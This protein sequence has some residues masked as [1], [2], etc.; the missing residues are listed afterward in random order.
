MQICPINQDNTNFK[1]LHVSKQSL[2]AMGTSRR[3]LLKNPMIKEAADKF[4][5]LVKPSK[6]M[7]EISN[8]RN[9]DIKYSY[10]PS[11]I[12]AASFLGL[13]T[14]IGAATI[15]T[16]AGTIGGG[17]LGF[18]IGPMFALTIKNG[19][20]VTKEGVLSDKKVSQILVQAGENFENGKLTGITSSIYELSRPKD[21]MPNIASELSRKMYETKMKTIDP[22]NL[23]TAEKYLEMLENYTPMAEHFNKKIN[24]KGDTLLTQFFDVVPDD[25][26]TLYNKIIDILK[27]I[28]GLDYNQK[29]SGNI[30]CLE[31][32]MNA[33]NEEVL[34]LVQDFEFNYTPELEY[35]FANIKNKNFKNKVQK[36]IIN[37]NDILDAVKI[38]SDD[39]LKK[40]EN[41]LDS[42]LCN[43]KKLA[44]DIE[45]TLKDM[46]DPVYENWFK[47]IYGKYMNISASNLID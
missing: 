1:A 21:N 25:G 36:L 22:D 23:F 20:F 34:P 41:Q 47:S 33:E 12:G 45:K 42:P 15:G 28:K 19:E 31:K 38:K 3:A 11:L 8:E 14:Y 44:K 10:I 32:I 24:D 6:N 9:L 39:A 26:K 43:R 5:V 40:L 30:S 16:V 46:K 29:D 2:K 27:N 37:F 17:V 13:M 4:E 18:L 7:T 35:T